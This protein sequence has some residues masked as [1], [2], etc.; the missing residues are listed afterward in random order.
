M[1]GH[2]DSSLLRHFLALAVEPPPVCPQVVLQQLEVTGLNTFTQFDVMAAEHRHSLEF[3]FKLERI[4]FRAV[5]GV[6]LSPGDAFNP[7]PPLQL[8][9][10][11]VS[12]FCDI[13]RHGQHRDSTQDPCLRPVGVVDSNAMTWNDIS[14]ESE[15]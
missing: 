5:V 9:P 8:E 12:S 3:G 1:C 10:V 13:P 6:R 15:N 4:A 14:S 7:A 2:E 11:E